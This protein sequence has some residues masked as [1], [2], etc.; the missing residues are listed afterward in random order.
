M[1]R[2]PHFDLSG[3]P[4]YLIQC[5]INRESSPGKPVQ[6]EFPPWINVP[7]GRGARTQVFTQSADYYAIDVYT[8]KAYILP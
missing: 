7:G 2:T 3:T 6:S 8:P 1:P 5:S 4:Q